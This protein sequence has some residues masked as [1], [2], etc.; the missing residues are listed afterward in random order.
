MSDLW[1]PA[2]VINP[3]L[4]SSVLLLLHKCIQ[5]C[6]I[7]IPCLLFTYSGVV[8]NPGVGFGVR[9]RETRLLRRTCSHSLTLNE[10]ICDHGFVLIRTLVGTQS[11]GVVKLEQ[12]KPVSGF[13]QS[14]VICS[15][16]TRR[17]EPQTLFLK[18]L[19]SFKNNL[20]L[21]VGIF[22][23]SFFVLNARNLEN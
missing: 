13:H 2:Q 23:H 22:I 20:S 17:T 4:D 21:V 11:Q 18:Y 6:T 16:F 15:V 5:R 12:R 8:L 1:F 14:A 10:T 9:I 3:S 7:T 19:N